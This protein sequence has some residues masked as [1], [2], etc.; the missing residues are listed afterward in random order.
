MLK[1]KITCPGCG[2]VVATSF[3]DAILWERC[4]GCHH[5]IWDSYDLLLADV[6]APE[7]Q[8]EAMRSGH[9]HADN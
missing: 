3:P 8:G 6:Y 4:P 1:F 5:H 9:V 7:K 2:V